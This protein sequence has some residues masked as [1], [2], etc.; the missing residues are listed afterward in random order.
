M[1]PFK[2]FTQEQVMGL[3][4]HLLTTVAGIIV[5]NGYMDSEASVQIVGGIVALVGVVWSLLSN[6]KEK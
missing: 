3:V 6:I 1:N 2:I 4:R 5:T